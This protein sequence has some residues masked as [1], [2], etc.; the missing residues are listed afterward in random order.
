[1]NYYSF[2]WWDLPILLGG[3]AMVAAMV[4]AVWGERCRC[5]YCRARRRAK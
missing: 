5:D 4:W 1:M 2:G 3:L